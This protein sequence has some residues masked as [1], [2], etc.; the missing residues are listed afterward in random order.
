VVLSLVVGIAAV[1]VLAAI[2]TRHRR[3][4][5]RARRA[6]LRHVEGLFTEVTVTQDG[7]GYPSLRGRWNGHWLKLDLVVD[8]LAMRQL[9]TLWMLVSVLRPLPVRTPIDITLRPRS[10]DIVSAGTAFAYEHDPPAG[11]PADIRVTT[12]EPALPPLEV[13]DRFVELLEQPSTKGLLIAPGGIRIVHALASGAV[14]QYRVTRR[15]KFAFAVEPERVEALLCMA[16]AVADRVADVGSRL[17]S[18]A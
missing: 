12:P 7:I 17:G 6:V 10:S 9:P 14:G 5:G 1:L 15:P 18:P 11:W 13:L 3:N 2:Q 4:V 8:T 16:D